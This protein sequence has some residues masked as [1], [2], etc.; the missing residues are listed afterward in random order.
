[1]RLILILTALAG[2]EWGYSEEPTPDAAP[3]PD[4][5]LAPMRAVETARAELLAA[6]A[7]V[8][9]LRWQMG[10]VLDTCPGRDRPPMW[11][12]EGR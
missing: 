3:T 1:M 5:D 11:R 7:E 6:T 12:K 4:A 8:E 2:C 9:L 10:V